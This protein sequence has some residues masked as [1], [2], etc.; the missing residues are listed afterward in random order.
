M[1]TPT[2]PINDGGPAFPMP[3][4]YHANGQVEYGTTGMYLRDWFA[5]QALIMLPHHG[6]A[7]DLDTAHTALA[8]YQIADAMLKAR[9]VRP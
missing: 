1:N 8:A 9:E 4:T 5:G 7:A 3:D 2:S 6:C